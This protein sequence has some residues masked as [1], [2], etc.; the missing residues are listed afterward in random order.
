ML[1]RVTAVLHGSQLHVDVLRGAA[2]AHGLGGGVRQRRVRDA[3]VLRD[4]LGSAGRA[5]RLVR[6]VEELFPGHRTVSERARV[7]IRPRS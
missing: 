1:A 6:L 3:M 4:R 7:S 5:D 2:F